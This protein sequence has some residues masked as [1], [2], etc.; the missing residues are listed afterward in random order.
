MGLFPSLERSI[1]RTYEVIEKLVKLTETLHRAEMAEKN[2]AGRG[3]E[4]NAKRTCRLKNG[5]N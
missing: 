3:M 4:P 5:G 1:S 2:K